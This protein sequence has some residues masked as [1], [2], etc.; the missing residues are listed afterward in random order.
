VRQLSFYTVQAKLTCAGQRNAI[1]M[2]LYLSLCLCTIAVTAGAQAPVPPAGPVL[3]TT[4]IDEIA[5]TTGKLQLV[6]TAN[7][8]SNQVL[9]TIQI[10]V[11]GATAQRQIEVKDIPVMMKLLEEASIK[12]ASGKPFTAEAGSLSATVSGAEDRKWLVL[13]FDSDDKVDTSQQFVVDAYNAR[14]MARA[15]AQSKQV[16]DWFIAKL[17]LLQPHMTI[18]R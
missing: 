12:L 17:P 4:E 9:T 5:T 15:L 13:K 6:V 1:A 16:S 11:A 7:L 18:I 10:K 8:T 2:K 3:L 14:Q